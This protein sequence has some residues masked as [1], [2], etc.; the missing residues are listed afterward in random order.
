MADDAITQAGIGVLGSF[1]ICA[2]HTLL[3]CMQLCPD[4]IKTRSTL[5]LG[6]INCLFAI[7]RPTL[8][9]PTN[10]TIFSPKSEKNYNSSDHPMILFI[11]IKNMSKKVSC[12]YLKKKK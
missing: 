8:E 9:K 7:T 2:L 3:S 6:L 5:K 11:F 1:Y 10:L 4:L 12:V